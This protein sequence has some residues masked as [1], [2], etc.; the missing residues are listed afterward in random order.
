MCLIKTLEQENS[1][2]G[3]GDGSE[4]TRGSVMR[5]KRCEVCKTTGELSLD[6]NS[7]AVLRIVHDM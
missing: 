4:I 5:S 3:K 1:L 6:G 7:S 2:L